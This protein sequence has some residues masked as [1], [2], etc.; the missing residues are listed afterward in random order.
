MRDHSDYS[1]RRLRL[2][3]VLLVGAALVVSMT[4]SSSAQKV[5]MAT[6]ATANSVFDTILKKMGKSWE[7]GTDGRVSLTVIAGGAAGDEPDII[8]KM[9]IGSYQG[10][11]ISVAGLTDIH[12]DFTIF[13]VPLFFDSFEEMLFV[14]REVTPTLERRLDEKG[15]KLLAW[16]YV[17]WVYFFSTQPVRTLE[18]LQDLK[19]MTLSGEETLL[20][21]W[22]SNGFKPVSIATTDIMMALETGMI[23]AITVPPLFAMQMQFYRKAKHM[24][25]LG[26]APMMGAVL[27]SKRTWD[28]IKESD[29]PVVLAAGRE[30]QAQVLAQIPKLDE[31]AIRL[32]GSQG[33]TVTKIKNSAAS[34]EWLEAAERFATTMRGDIVPESIF[35]EA[36]AARTA[37]REKQAEGEA[38]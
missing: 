11:A 22:R 19:M 15:F 27:I 26:L 2:R 30:A 23:E 29:R 10:G 32:M 37:Y 28:R 24:A 33:L 6:L 4:S 9:R 8:R 7:E 31:T 12:K 3:V 18:D 13:E 14:L 20:R 17:G 34:Q 25:D 36:L 1:A 35:D 38:P 5:K 21:W 16:G